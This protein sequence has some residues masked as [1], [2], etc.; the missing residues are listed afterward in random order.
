MSFLVEKMCSLRFGKRKA[1]L[2]PMHLKSYMQ[3][4]MANLEEMKGTDNAT[5]ALLYAF[6]NL[7][8]RCVW[9]DQEDMMQMMQMII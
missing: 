1:K 9:N 8:D 2:P 3:T 7:R 6:G 5:E 4:I